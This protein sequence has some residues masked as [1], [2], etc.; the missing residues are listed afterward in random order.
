MVM[1]IFLLLAWLAFCIIMLIRPLPVSRRQRLSPLADTEDQGEW[2]GVREPRRPWPPNWPPRAAAA[3]P[4]DSKRQEPS[5]PVE[6]R[7]TP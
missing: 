3:I 2:S 4:D 5:N 7:D 1:A 6:Y